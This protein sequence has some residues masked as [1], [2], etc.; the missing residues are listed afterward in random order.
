MVGHIKFGIQIND[1]A[2]EVFVERCEIGFET[3]NKFT[4]Q[5]EQNEHVINN[6]YYIM[7]NTIMKC[8]FK[9]SHIIFIFQMV[10]LYTF[11]TVGLQIK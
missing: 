5:Y 7:V 2:L 9:L 8:F 11:F 10:V 3:A 6:I 4:R 1:H